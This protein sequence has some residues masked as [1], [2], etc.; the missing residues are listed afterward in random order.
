MSNHVCSSI[1]DFPLEKFHQIGSGKG[2]NLLIVGESPAPKGWILSGKACYRPDGKLLPTGK[3]LNELLEPLGLSVENSGFTELSKCFV[4]KR[5]ELESCGKKCWPIFLDQISGEDY[6]LLIILGVQTTAILSKIIERD[7]T[8][9]EMV[10]IELNGRSYKIFPIFH[11]SP[12]NP[13]GYA[14][15]KVLFKNFLPKMKKVIK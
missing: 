15:N 14:K 6:K 1:E 7:L 11:P 10:D 8:M 9:G 2:R 5:T 4:S 13:T 3:R 12:A